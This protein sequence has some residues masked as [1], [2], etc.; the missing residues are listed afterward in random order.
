MG[1]LLYDYFSTFRELE[2]KTDRLNEQSE[3]FKAQAK[4]LDQARKKAE[5]AKGR[6]VK[7][8]LEKLQNPPEETK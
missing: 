5:A 4:A 2:Q 6:L 7:F 1:G 3:K 8:R